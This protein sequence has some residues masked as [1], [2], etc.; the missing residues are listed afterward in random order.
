MEDG[1]SVAN[2]GY[3]PSPSGLVSIEHQAGVAYDHRA[4]IDTLG[5]QQHSLGMDV[6]LL[7]ASPSK[8][9]NEHCPRTPNHFAAAVIRAWTVARHRIR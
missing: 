7:D 1:I 5:A 9:P 4:A 2:T 6:S 8:S 3:L